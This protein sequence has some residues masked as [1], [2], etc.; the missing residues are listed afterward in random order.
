[1]PSPTQTPIVSYKQNEKG[2]KDSKGKFSWVIVKH[3][4]PPRQLREKGRI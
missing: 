4:G 3:A 1:M 2:K